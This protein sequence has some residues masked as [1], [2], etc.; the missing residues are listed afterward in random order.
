MAAPSLEH[1][2]IFIFG[3]QMTENA[4]VV[5][6][7]SVATD[8]ESAGD[9]TDMVQLMLDMQHIED[10]ALEP[11]SDAPPYP[12]KQ[13]QSVTHMVRH[14][15]KLK[16]DT[17][18]MTAFKEKHGVIPGLRKSEIT[19][20][21]YYQTE[22]FQIR[23]PQHKKMIQDLKIAIAHYRKTW[24]KATIIHDREVAKQK[25]EKDR[26]AKEKLKGSKKNKR[27]AEIKIKKEK[28]E[29]ED[30]DEEEEY[31]SDHC[32]GKLP[33][34]E[35]ANQRDSHQ[36]YAMLQDSTMQLER[37]ARRLAADYLHNVENM[38]SEHWQAIQKLN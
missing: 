10:D 6:N 38:F 11:E 2:L 13:F 14:Y 19:K 21:P 28:D 29:E 26:K 16:D 12:V 5:Q 37:K 36:F 22:E 4:E 33:R 20:Q 3:S 8:T 9:G 17:F 27:K 24:P 30:D 18:S 34:I 23:V 7:N 35:H 15:E 25:L 1:K 32:V 31:A